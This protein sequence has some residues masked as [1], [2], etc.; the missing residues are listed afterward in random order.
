MKY[1]VC[2]NSG[3]KIYE[4]EGDCRDAGEWLSDTSNCE[5][6]LTCSDTFETIL[7]NFGECACSVCNNIYIAFYIVFSFCLVFI[8]FIQGTLCALCTRALSFTHVYIE[9]SSA[10]KYYLF[11]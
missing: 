2:D 5:Y 6:M 11:E 4:F 3:N 7:T 8:A 9:I 1:L 10:Q